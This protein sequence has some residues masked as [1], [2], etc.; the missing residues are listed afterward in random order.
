MGN[1][2]KYSLNIN[3]L[4]L[5][6]HE[7]SLDI[8]DKFFSN[9]E[10]G[11]ISRGKAKANIALTKQSNM[12]TLDFDIKGEAMVACDRCLGD[13]M[14]PIDYQGILF[15]KYS[16]EEK[17][18]EADVIWIREGDGEVGLAQYIYDSISLS[19]PYQRVHPDGKCDPEMM[20][21]FRIVSQEEFN[22]IALKAEQK[23]ESGS[24]EKQLGDLKAKM[25]K[26]EKKK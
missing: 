26:D 2:N 1:S 14:I 16:E 13:F 3:G 23:E 18:D 22:D 20:K 15:V 17:E 25:E 6:K 5:G 11:E 10:G 19:L 8:D 9:F 12:L 7:F 24:W 4:P 21:R